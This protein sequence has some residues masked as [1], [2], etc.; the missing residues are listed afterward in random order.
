MRVPPVETRVILAIMMNGTMPVLYK[1]E[2]TARRVEAVHT[3]RYST[4]A[5]TVS[6][7]VLP[8]G[9]YAPI[10]VTFTFAHVRGTGKK[11]HIKGGGSYGGHL[12]NGIQRRRRGYIPA[13]RFRHSVYCTHGIDNASWQCSMRGIESWACYIS[14]DWA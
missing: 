7:L 4:K 10:T 8:G 12:R 1:F 14:S 9:G 2:I 13:G 11:R 3:S 6:R 5:M